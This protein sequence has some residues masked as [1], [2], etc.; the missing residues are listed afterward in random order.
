MRDGAL[1][2]TAGELRVSDEDG[3][4]T[5][6]LT[7]AS[8]GRVEADKVIVNGGGLLSG[9]GGTIAA[10][11]VLNGGTIAPGAS[12]GI[13]NIDGDL[14]VLDGL[15][16]FEIGGSALGMFDQLFVSGDLITPSGL[17]IEISFLDS[18]LPQMGDTFDFLTVDGDA[19]IFGDPDSI[20]FSFFGDNPGLDFSFNSGGFSAVVT[21]GGGVSPVPLPASLPLLLAA[22][23]GLAWRSRK[24]KAA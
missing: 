10:D 11:V 18:F 21:G 12:P 7:V 3:E 23:G 14:E 2:S 24:A 17:N 19:P 22:V 6:F 1:L 15:L 8:G 16:S 13:M 5:G 20:S 4:G 9:N